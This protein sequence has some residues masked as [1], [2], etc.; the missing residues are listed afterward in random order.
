[1]NGELEIRPIEL[2]PPLS[3]ELTVLYPKDPPKPFRVRLHFDSLDHLFADVRQAYRI[4]EIFM[5]QRPADIWHYVWCE[6][7]DVPDAIQYRLEYTREK[8]VAGR[9]WPQ[10]WY[11]FPHFDAVFWWCWDDTE[12]EDSCWLSER[13]KEYFKS[14]AREEFEKVRQVC[15][16]VS[17]SD[18]TIVRHFLPRILSAE[19]PFDYLIEC[20][21]CLTRPDYK[22]PT[23]PRRS[24]AFYDKL[25]EIVARD[26]IR[27]VASRGDSDYLVNRILCAEQRLRADRSQRGPRDAFPV[28]MVS[29]GCRYIEEWGGQVVFYQEG[30]GGADLLVDSPEQRSIKMAVEQRRDKRWP[31][32]FTD[33]DEGE[34][35]GY[36][37]EKGSDWIIYRRNAN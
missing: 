12:P 7:L 16:D 24:R 32:I 22:S 3:I 33:R 25:S 19:H 21:R 18:S 29:D 34:I 1:M 2:R 35:A 27:S 36:R 20:K 8:D 10:N 6:V 4:Y 17:A 30:L 14:I 28:C 37:Q 13:K 15:A 26:D 31:T 11:P 5:I 9:H 23:L